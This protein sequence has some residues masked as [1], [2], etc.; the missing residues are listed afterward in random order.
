[1]PRW[2]IR[3]VNGKDVIELDL[4]IGDIAERRAQRQQANKRCLI[5]RCRLGENEIIGC[6]GLQLPGTCLT[7]GGADQAI[8]IASAEE[9]GTGGCRG[10]LEGI[11]PL[12]AQR[13]VLPRYT[14]L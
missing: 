1:M 5:N 11:Q 4:D 14:S 12:R 3:R 2:R 8:G 13:Q 6:L 7:G 9:E 10:G